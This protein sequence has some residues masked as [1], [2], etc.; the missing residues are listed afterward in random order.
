VIGVIYCVLISF[1]FFFRSS[2]FAQ[3]KALNIPGIH[4]LVADSRAEHERQETASNRQAQNTLNEQANRALLFKLK[5]SY[6]L[7]QSRFSFLG[8]AVS[9]AE[10]G[11]NALPLVSRIIADQSRLYDAATRDPL[12]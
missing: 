6:R 10:V 12:L 4:Q 2:V 3:R 1:F 11:L 7:L 9:A 5:D 8:T